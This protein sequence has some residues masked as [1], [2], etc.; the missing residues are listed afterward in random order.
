[1]DNIEHI[2]DFEGLIEWIDKKTESY[3]RI[4][5]NLMVFKDIIFPE[6]SLNAHLEEDV[7]Y[8][9]LRD[10]INETLRNCK[11]I[12]RKIDLFEIMLESEENFDIFK[13]HCLDI[14][15]MHKHYAKAWNA[16]AQDIKKTIKYIREREE[17]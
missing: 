10:K 14:Q 13:E 6:N 4:K 3:H 1:M 11:I 16:I 12:E 8:F 2:N 7:K 9:K 17:E 5:T 15:R